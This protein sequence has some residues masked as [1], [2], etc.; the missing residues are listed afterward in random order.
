[1]T[2]QI[3][4]QFEWAVNSPTSGTPTGSFPG[5]V[6]QNVAGEMEG[7]DDNGVAAEKSWKR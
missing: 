7:V 5:Q 2:D 6:A 1:M 3:H 4:L